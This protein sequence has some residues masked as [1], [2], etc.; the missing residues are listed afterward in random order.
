MQPTKLAQVWSDIFLCL[1]ANRW[2]LYLNA[3]KNAFSF[4]L[5]IG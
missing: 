2:E 3:T 1:N 5:A 4:S